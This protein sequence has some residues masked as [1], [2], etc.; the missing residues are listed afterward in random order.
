MKE[1]Q[2]T[3]IRFKFNGEPY[4]VASPNIGKLRDFAKRNR[5]SDDNFDA[6]IDLIVEQGL[7]RE[8]AL[9]LEADHIEWLMSEMTAKKKS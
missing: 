7:P 4:E 2:T 3:K 8:V 6:T 5:D 1:L 9:S